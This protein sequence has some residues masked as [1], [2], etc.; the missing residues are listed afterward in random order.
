MSQLFIPSN[1][2]IFGLIINFIGGVA[3]TLTSQFGTATAWGGNI[4][5]KNKFW[6]ITNKFGWYLMCAGFIF[7]IIAKFN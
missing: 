4:K 3:I 6:G 5:E 1:I 2:E 7:Q